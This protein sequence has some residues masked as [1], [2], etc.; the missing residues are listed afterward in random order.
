ML[1]GTGIDE[2]LAPAPGFASLRV[3]TGGSPMQDPAGILAASQFGDLLAR[4]DWAGMVFVDTP[5]SALFADALPIASRCDCTIVVV[6][7]QG[8]RRGAVRRL[9]RQLDQI[10]ANT[11]G[12]VL[13]RTEPVSRSGY[14]NYGNGS[15]ELDEPT[16]QG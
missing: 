15:R 16:V 6:D 10:G 14:S 1:T 13:N 5:A 11:I 3:I 8:T 9:T 2:A 7:A 12:V 4:L